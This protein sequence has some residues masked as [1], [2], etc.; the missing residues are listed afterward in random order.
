MTVREELY[1]QIK[2]HLDLIGINGADELFIFDEDADADVSNRAVKH[3]DLW[4]HNVE[5][6]EQET[7]WE[8]PAVFIEFQ[9]I[10]WHEIVTGVEYR[11]DVF[12]NL[13]VVTDWNESKGI[14][15]F[16]L[17]EKIHEVLAGLSGSTFREFDI[18]TSM[19]NHNHEDIVENIET[20]HC[21]GFRHLKQAQ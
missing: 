4:N 8:R 1:R 15:E 5:F 14:G 19:T 13:H 2:A 16:R 18:D 17:L 20:Y 6:I 21:V 10:K 7:A 3:I 11:A 12:V 9:P